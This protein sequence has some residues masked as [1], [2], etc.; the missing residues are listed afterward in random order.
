MATEVEQAALKAAQSA[1]A[2][3]KAALPAA[4]PGAIWRLVNFP[5]VAEAINYANLAPAQKGGEFG[6][7][8]DPAGGVH[9]YYFF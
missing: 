7:T 4:S 3:Q 1:Q 5:N 6:V 8:D 9:G 2:A